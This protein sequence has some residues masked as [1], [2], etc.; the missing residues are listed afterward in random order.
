MNSE[1]FCVEVWFTNHNSKLLEIEDCR[2][3]YLLIMLNHPPQMNLQLL[4][5]EQF[6]KLHHR[7]VLGQLKVKPKYQR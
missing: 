6:K 4:Q 2:L 3:H 5:K 1:F 7:I